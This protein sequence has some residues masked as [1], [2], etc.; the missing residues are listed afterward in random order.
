MFRRSHW[1]GKYGQILKNRGRVAGGPFAGMA[2]VSE[3]VGSQFWPKIFGTYE[4][5]LW[6]VFQRLFTMPF[7]RIVD[8]GAAE[9]FYAVGAA[10]KW[11]GAEVIAFESE[12]HGRDL[13]GKMARMNAVSDRLRVE[14]ECTPEILSAVLSTHDRSPTLCIMDVEGAEADLCNPDRIPALARCHLI[15]ETHEFQQPGITRLLEDRFATTHLV[16]PILPRP[17]TLCDF[18]DSVPFP[19]RQLL[20]QSLVYVVDEWRHADCSWLLIQPQELASPKTDPRKQEV[21]A[22]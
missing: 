14:G 19:I 12:Q 5:E 7:N 20:G 4:C 18:R 2:Y 13:L 11:P 6:P 10:V 21:K 3:S 1:T 17:R 15:V 16:E 9:G 22:G 8:V